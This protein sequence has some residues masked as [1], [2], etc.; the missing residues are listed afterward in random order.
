MTH[1][2][3]DLFDS[4]KLSFMSCRLSLRLTALDRLTLSHGIIFC[5]DKKVLKDACI[6]L[7]DQMRLLCRSRNLNEVFGVATTLYEWQIVYYS[8]TKEL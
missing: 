2:P 4:L 8:R 3:F 6:S 5:T 1:L 7:M